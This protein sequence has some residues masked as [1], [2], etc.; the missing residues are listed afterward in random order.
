MLRIRTSHS[1]TSPQKRAWERKKGSFWQ[2]DPFFQAIL[3]ETTRKKDF[4]ETQCWTNILTPRHNVATMLQCCDTLKI[5]VANCPI[6]ETWPL[7]EA[8]LCEAKKNKKRKKV[9]NNGFKK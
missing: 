1:R 3:H 8:R 7:V 9:E 6:V 4:R 2:L 5:V